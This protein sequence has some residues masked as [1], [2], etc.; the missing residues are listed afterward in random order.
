MDFRSIVS[1]DMKVHLFVNDKKI[2]NEALTSLKLKIIENGFEIVEEG[3]DLAIA[4]GG[5]GTFLRMVKETNFDS[6]VLYVGINYGTLG[7]LQEIKLEDIDAFFE[8]LKRSHYRL[9]EISVQET[10]V[11]HEGGDSRFYSLNEIV[12]RES[13]LKVARMDVFIDN[14]YL[15]KFIGDG[16]LITSS[17]GST[18]YNLSFG[19]AIVYDTFSTLQLTPIAPINTQSYR[20]IFNPIVIP[21]KKEIT[22]KPIES[23]EGIIVTVDGENNYY[24][25]VQEIKTKIDSKKIKFLRLSHYNFS[26]KINEK[27]LSNP[28][29]CY[30]LSG[31][32]L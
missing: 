24:R 11:S 7:F 30:N 21:S 1:K 27:L 5:D 3:Y 8:E 10:V 19:G 31:G 29:S 4:L 15:E 25:N 16:M 2:S 14:D 9:D 23:K 12:I 32:S 6:N 18:A 20:T 13:N 22:L 26:Q 28:L 17:I